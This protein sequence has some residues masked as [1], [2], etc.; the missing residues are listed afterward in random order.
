MSKLIDVETLR[1][2][3][4]VKQPVTVVDVRSDDDRAQWAIPD[5]LHVNACDALRAATA[6]P[7][8]HVQLPPDRPVVTV[9]NAGRLSQVAADL[10]AARGFD[11]HSLIGGMKAWSTAWNVAAVPLPTSSLRV[12]QVRRTGK[13]CL[14]YVVGSGGEAAVID[15]SV[16]S[17]VYAQIAADHGWRIRHVIE[18]HVHADHLSRARQLAAETAATLVLPPQRRVSFPF[19]PIADG[20]QISFGAA[21]LIAMHTPGHTDESTSY[22]LNGIAVFTGDT[23][24]THGV[25]RPDLHTNTGDVHRRA[26]ALFA[27]LN[28]LQQLPSD[29]MVLPAHTSEPI[30]FDG[31]PVVGQFAEIRTWLS[32]WLASEDAFVD[33]MTSKLP[34]T[35]PNFARIVELNQLGEFPPDNPTDLEA[36]ANRCAVR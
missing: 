22:G 6:G 19:T 27:S 17:D 26:R 10:L 11:T 16:S 29:T 1:D 30:A 12:I 28:R 2:W 14:S 3:L 20:E 33:R 31:R 25:G 15:A 32:E 34:P 9:C 7:L 36:G 4:D 13:G 21:T 35:P 23:L 5:S 8:E 24:F 18:T